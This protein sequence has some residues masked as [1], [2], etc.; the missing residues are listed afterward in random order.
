M[1]RRLSSRL[2]GAKKTKKT[3]KQKANCYN[4]GSMGSQLQWKFVCSWSIGSGL[5]KDTS[6]GKRDV[7]LCRE[8]CWMARQSQQ[9]PQ[10][11]SHGALSWDGSFQMSWTKVRG[12]GFCNS[13]WLVIWCGVTHVEGNPWGGTQQWAVSRQHNQQ[14]GMS[15][16]VPK[17]GARAHHV[18]YS[19]PL[20]L[21]SLSGNDS[22]G[23]P[24]DFFSWGK[25]TTVRFVRWTIAPHHS[26]WSQDCNKYHLLPLLPLLDSSPLQPAPVCLGGSPRP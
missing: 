7:G 11:N 20:A 9:S 13:H 18:C 12:S 1:Y 19:D 17:G 23:I 22:F 26:L 5:G 6:N 2:N 16:S 21:Y 10:P 24:I 3:K 14:L 8:R 4:L 25:L 15:V